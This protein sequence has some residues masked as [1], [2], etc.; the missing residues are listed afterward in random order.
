M[1]YGC[2]LDDQEDRKA[3]FVDFLR[4]QEL[5]LRVLRL[6]CGTDLTCG[7][8]SST[9]C[10][11]LKELDLT[12]VNWEDEGAALVA[13]AMMQ[14]QAELKSMEVFELHATSCPTLT[15]S[16]FGY[17]ISVVPKGAMPALRHLRHRIAGGG[18]LLE[19]MGD[20][21][22]AS[23][24]ESGHS[25]CLQS[26]TIFYLPMN[27]CSML[28][29]V[30]HGLMKGLCPNLLELTCSRCPLSEAE[31][32]AI[33]DL[34]RSGACPLL[35]VLNL[36]VGRGDKCDRALVRVIIDRGRSHSPAQDAEY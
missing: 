14:K 11:A 20:R 33:Y 13:R 2:Y 9:S 24:L 15:P 7:I 25:S 32:F 16:G 31:A 34:L 26:L 6:S 21:L 1:I 27:H 3:S 36:P 30:A 19:G 35:Q 18:H 8:L 5:P 22:L 12:M 23:A 10:Q 29:N 17:I 4:R 28:V